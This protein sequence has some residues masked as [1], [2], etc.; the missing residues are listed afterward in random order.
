MV[1]ALNMAAAFHPSTAVRD[2]SRLLRVSGLALAGA[3]WVLGVFPPPPA[4][5]LMHA[6]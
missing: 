3:V 4:V 6:Y 5:L 2:D 1:G